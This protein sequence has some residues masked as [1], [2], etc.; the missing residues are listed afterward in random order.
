MGVDVFHLDHWVKVDRVKQ[1]VQVQ[2]CGC[3]IRVSLSNF[4]VK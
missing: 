1:L 2:L 3:G 4:G